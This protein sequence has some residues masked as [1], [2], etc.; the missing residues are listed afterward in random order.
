MLE[1]VK[2]LLGIEDD[3]QDE[4]LEIIIENVEAHLY[5]LLGKSTPST[6]TFVVSEITVI[7][8]NR[9]GSEGMKSDLAEGHRVDFFEPKDDFRPYLTLIENEREA[10]TPEPEAKK[11]RVMF[12]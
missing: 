2:K 10:T 11:G 9:L 5:A 3:L 4:V 6:L 12:I 8:Y 7:R 1:R